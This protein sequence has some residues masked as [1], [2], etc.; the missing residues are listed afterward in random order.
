MATENT[1]L[2]ADVVALSEQYGVPHVLLI[3]RAKDPHKGRWAL[4]G[5][6]V[7]PGEDVEH[8]A[9]RELVEETG[10]DP[11]HLDPVGV[12]SAPGR[13]PRGRYVSF[14]YT[15]RMTRLVTPAAGSDAAAAEWVP[16]H[17]ALA[18]GLAFDHTRIVS[19][20]LATGST[21]RR[22]PMNY[23]IHNRVDGGTVGAQVGMHFGRGSDL[24]DDAQVGH[25]VGPDD[26]GFEDLRA[27]ADRIKRAARAAAAGGT[28]SVTNT[29]SND[30]DSQVGFQADVIRG[31]V[32][33]QMGGTGGTSVVINGQVW[34]RYTKDDL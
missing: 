12:Y 4:P 26:A 27:F 1:R 19:E 9:R 29:N 32:G 14:A 18:E 34:Q 10:I 28:F 6:H 11:G 3:R 7:D 33:V 13:D 23:N 17:A 22:K 20:A 8:A 16:V 24:P 30:G 15:T 31:D 25:V 21:R 5:G 2:T